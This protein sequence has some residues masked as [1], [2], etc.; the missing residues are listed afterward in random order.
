VSFTQ[1]TITHTFTNADGT[2]ASG[3]IEFTL[4]K[5]MTNGVNSI[6]P[7]SITA[8][9]DASGDLSQALTSNGDTGTSPTD[10]QWRV[11]IRILG[12]QNV[13]EFI[14]V[15]TGGGSIDLATLLPSTQQV[16]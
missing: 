9:L 4:T 5:M 6:V 1:S 11:D 13:T 12:A 14:V 8:N 7:A 2:P 15:P 16:G 10:A 3:S